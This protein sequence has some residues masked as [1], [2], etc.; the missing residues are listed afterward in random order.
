VTAMRRAEE[1]SDK[2]A[3]PIRAGVPLE[4]RFGK[5]PPILV[6]S[7]GRRASRTSRDTL[8]TYTPGTAREAARSASFSR[9]SGLAWIVTP[10]KA[11]AESGATHLPITAATA[12]N[13]GQPTA[14]PRGSL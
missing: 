8:P 10:A 6:A 7:G 3:S 2:Q 14:H 13:R 1:E 5:L 11:N 12:S 4:P 9:M